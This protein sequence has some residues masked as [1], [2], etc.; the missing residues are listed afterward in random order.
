[1]D[2]ERRETWKTLDLALRVGEMLL[3]NG[4]GAA[5]VTSTMLSVTTAC[6]LRGVT[7][8]VTYTQLTLTHQPS[9]DE[10]GVIQIR[11]VTHREI[12]YEDLTL[13]DHL[14]RDLLERRIT[15]DEARDQVNRLAS[16]AHRR[17]RWAVTVGWGVMGTGIAML[18]SAGF[19]VSCLAFV[20]AAGI[21]RVQRA[22]S[23]RRLP[24]FYQQVAGGLLATL[25][26]VAASAVDLG[27]PHAVLPGDG[28]HRRS[29]VCGTGSR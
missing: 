15:R 5:D 11:R 1:M 27:V 22:L 28:L 7:S 21:D 18:L 4:A 19:V 2:E 23:L 13:V 9:V 25:I 17:P 20:A 29:D 24:S 12:D 14:V 26:A 16:S 3:S 8:D 10:P 6:G